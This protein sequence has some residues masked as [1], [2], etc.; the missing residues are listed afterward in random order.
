MLAKQVNEFVKDDVAVFMILASMKEESKS[1]LGKLPVVSDFPEVFLDDTSDLPPEREVEFT[2]DL[3]VGTS[4][5]LMDP[6]RM[7]AS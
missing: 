7:S 3:V 2:I 1:V 4:L 5:V 6:Y